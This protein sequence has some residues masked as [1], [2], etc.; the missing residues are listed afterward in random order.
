LDKHQA[1]GDE[2]EEVVGA[3]ERTGSLFEK[4]EDNKKEKESGGK[5]EFVGAENNTAGKGNKELVKESGDVTVGKEKKDKEAGEKSGF[6]EGEQ[7]AKKDE[8]SG[9]E[10]KT[11]QQGHLDNAGR[12]LGLVGGVEEEQGKKGDEKRVSVELEE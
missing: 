2:S 6:F 10:D 11:E 8:R 7:G 4:N 1:K 12:K 3:V 5:E 9:G